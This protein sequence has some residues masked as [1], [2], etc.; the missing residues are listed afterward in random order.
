MYKFKEN[1]L[2]YIKQFNLS[3]IAREIGITYVYLTNII[4]NK[5]N[6]KKTVAYCITK[7]LDEKAE[8]SEYFIEI[9]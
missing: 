3:Q 8:I 6:C 1:K 9:I 5:K 2:S 7:F 4:H